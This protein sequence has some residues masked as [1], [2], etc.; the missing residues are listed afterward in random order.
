[1][2]SLICLMTSWRGAR[3][4]DAIAERGCKQ[5]C[6]LDNFKARGSGLCRLTVRHGVSYDTFLTASEQSRSLCV[7]GSGRYLGPG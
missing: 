5:Q 4:C 6:H 2:C 1:M 3:A 7:F